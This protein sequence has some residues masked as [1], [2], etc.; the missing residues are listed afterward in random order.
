MNQKNGFGLIV[1][2]VHDLSLNS[3][4]L[5]LREDNIGYSRKWTG[6]FKLLAI[7]KEICKLQLPSGPTN[8]RIITVKPYLQEHSDTQNPILHDLQDSE[9]DLSQLDKKNNNSNNKV[10]LDAPETTCRNPAC[11]HCFPARF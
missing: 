9:S 10:D 4:V 6:P 1:S 2:D 3:D 7:D 8:F 5:V 11:T